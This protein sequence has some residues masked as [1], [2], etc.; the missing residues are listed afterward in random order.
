MNIP[1][2]LYHFQDADKLYVFG[3][4]KSS[5]FRLETKIA[6]K[7]TMNNDN[8]NHNINEIAHISK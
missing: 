7:K 2:R 6:V 3:T 5:N 4:I 1:E 8:D